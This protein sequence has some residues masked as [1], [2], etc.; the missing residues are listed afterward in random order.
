MERYVKSIGTLSLEEVEF[1]R[2]I[3]VAVAGC[4]GLGGYVVELLARLGVGFLTLVDKD[5]FEESNLN[6]QLFCDLNSLGKFK[7]LVAKERLKIVNPEV[8]VNAIIAELNF[9]NGK[10]FLKNHDLVIDALDTPQAKKLLEEICEDLNI[11]LVHGAVAGWYGQIATIFPGDR[12]LRVL[13]FS[14]TSGME[15][16]IGVPPF[17]PSLVASFQVSEA[18]K[19]LFKKGEV[20]RKKVLFIDLLKNEFEIIEF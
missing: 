5:V 13:Y 7:V 19:V 11:P 14:K 18:L 16:E 12:L 6:R 10:N 9:K 3:K 15:K 17:T 8:E 4:G 20:L 2:K 1:L